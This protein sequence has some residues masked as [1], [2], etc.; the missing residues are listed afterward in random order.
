MR[1]ELTLKMLREAPLSWLKSE[2]YISDLIRLFG[3]ADNLKIGPYGEDNIY[4][5]DPGIYQVPEQLAKLLVYLSD[6]KIN[7]YLEIGVFNGGNFLFTSEYLKRFNPALKTYGLDLDH[8]FLNP[9]IGALVNGLV[10]AT[11]EDIQG[12]EIDY[13][14]IDAEHSY[15]WVTKDWLNVGQHA[16]ICAFHDINDK[17]LPDMARFWGKLK[18]DKNYKEFLDKGIFGIGVITT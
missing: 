12:S 1:I 11:S 7:T 18:Q 14:F 9:K 2:N 3:L 13:V 5:N 8:R 16:K 6:K 4:I 17:T 10:T 15:E